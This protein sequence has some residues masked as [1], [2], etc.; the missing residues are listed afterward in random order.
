MVELLVEAV[1]VIDILI[2]VA[3]VCVENAKTWTVCVVYCV[4]RRVRGVTENVASCVH[5]K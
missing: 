1:E 3:T 4:G 5:Y 2:R